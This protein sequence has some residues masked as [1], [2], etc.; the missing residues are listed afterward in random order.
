MTP[1]EICAQENHPAQFCECELSAAVEAER[2]RWMKRVGFL[3]SATR[4]SFWVLSCLAEGHC[5]L[6]DDLFAA[7]RQADGSER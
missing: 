7:I 3:L 1:E 2:E 6:C 5:D 4:M